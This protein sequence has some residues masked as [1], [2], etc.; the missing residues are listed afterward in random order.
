M[1]RIIEVSLE[2]SLRLVEPLEEMIAA[3]RN[4]P[5]TGWCS[6]RLRDSGEVI[7]AV[8][9]PLHLTVSHKRF[10]RDSSLTD[11]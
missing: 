11:G 1:L 4:R 2:R 10:Q 3:E 7:K 5:L 6:R 9:L 8:L